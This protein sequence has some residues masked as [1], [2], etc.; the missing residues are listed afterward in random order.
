MFLVVWERPSTCVCQDSGGP[1][2]NETVLKECEPRQ[3]LFVIQSSL[4]TSRMKSLQTSSPP[5]GS[6]QF[7][8]RKPRGGGFLKSRG[9]CSL[10]LRY[11]VRPRR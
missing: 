1:G 10:L 8:P 5:W 4:S 9:T 7:P 3:K 11:Y 2:Q 6:R